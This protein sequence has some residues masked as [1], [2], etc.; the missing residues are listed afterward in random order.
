[1]FDVNNAKKDIAYNEAMEILLPVWKSW[2]ES[3]NIK[4]K[5]CDLILDTDELLQE[6]T[7]N[8]LIYTST[9]LDDYPITHVVYDKDQI[10]AVKEKITKQG[11]Y[12]L[13]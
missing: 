2:K 1:M 10:E 6:D 7:G 8:S 5:H 11:I 12:W 3:I 13:Q 4:F 9:I